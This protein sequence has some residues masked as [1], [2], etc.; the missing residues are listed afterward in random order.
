MSRRA[1]FRSRIAA[2]RAGSAALFAVA[3]VA[4]SGCATT[5]Y[6]DGKYNSDFDKRLDTLGKLV[7]SLIE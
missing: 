3:L 6:E 1:E 7:K 2:V 4:L 5:K